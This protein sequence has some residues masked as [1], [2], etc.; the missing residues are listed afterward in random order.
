MNVFTFC[1][2]FVGLCRSFAHQKCAILSPFLSFLLVA[3]LS[4]TLQR[5]ILSWSCSP[6]QLGSVVRRVVHLSQLAFRYLSEAC[7]FRHRCEWFEQVVEN[8]PPLT[9]SFFFWLHRRVHVS[10]ASFFFRVADCTLLTNTLKYYYTHT[11]FTGKYQLYIPI[12]AFKALG[13]S[14]PSG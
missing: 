7:W 6:S 2:C 8:F 12:A 5:A 13:N 10:P 3:W 4:L 14:Q 11:T 9:K 1:W